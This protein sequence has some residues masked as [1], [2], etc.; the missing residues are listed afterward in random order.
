VPEIYLDYNATTPVLDAAIEAM[1]PLLRDGWGNPS[2]AHSFGRRAREAIELA[3]AEVAACIGASPDEIVF[4]SGGTEANN[5]AIVGACEAT[6]ERRH[7]VTSAI[8]HPATVEPLRALERR[9]WRVTRASVD[10]GGRVETEPAL[11]AIDQATALVTVMHSN[12]EVGTI[13]PIAALARTARARGALVHADAAQSLGKVEVDVNAL[14]VD[15]LSIAGHKLYAPKGVGALYVRRGV[16]LEPVLRGAGQERGVRPGTE[17]AHQIAALGAACRVARETLL[18][19]R[20]HLTAMSVALWQELTLRI[21]GVARNGATLPELRLPNT[22]NVSFPGVSGA[23]LL[24]EAR[25][26]AASTGSACHAGSEEPSAVLSA[27]G[28]D[29]AR[30]LGAVRLTVGRATTR[31]EVRRAAEELARAWTTLHG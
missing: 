13:Q 21:P 30:A 6:S 9:G 22:L 17:P 23:A 27:M 11:A 5:L 26:V 12:N 7:V 24:A 1:L 14:E 29:R 20:D 2:S 18:A 10:A 15:L 31:E 8:E 4:T 3:R 16:R 28:I 19:T 25:G